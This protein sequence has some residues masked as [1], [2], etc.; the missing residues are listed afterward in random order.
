MTGLA[1]TPMPDFAETTR[2]DGQRWDLVA[3]VRSLRADAAK[4]N[5]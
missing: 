5:R 4:E 3:Y 2:D 1:G